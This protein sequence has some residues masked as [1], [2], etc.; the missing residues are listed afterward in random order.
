MLVGTA[1]KSCASGVEV[2]ESEDANRFSEL[3]SKDV[4]AEAHTNPMTSVAHIKGVDDLSGAMHSKTAS[5]GNIG[6]C[7]S[8]A[9]QLG[10]EGKH[11]IVG[12][13]G[14]QDSRIRGQA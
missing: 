14:K 1:G 7:R 5:E 6:M 13:E 8:A 4:E 2:S 12:S 11:D 3:S 10:S 9:E